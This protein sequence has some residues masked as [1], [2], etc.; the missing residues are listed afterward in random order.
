MNFSEFNKHARLL[1][2]AC[3]CV[4]L[5]AVINSGKILLFLHPR[6]LLLIK[7]GWIVLVALTLNELKTFLGQNSRIKLDWR[8]FALMFPILA[9][10]YVNPTGLS[11]RIAVQKGVSSM[12]LTANRNTPLP[13]CLVRDTAGPVAYTI[14]DDSMYAQLDRLYADP[15][16]HVGEIITMLGFV[17]PDTILG[18]KSFF[19]ARMMV[20]CCAADGMPIGFYCATDS[21][22]GIHENDWVILTGK[23][24][25]RSV[26]FPWNT[27]KKTIPLL[28]MISVKKA[29]KPQNEYVYPVAY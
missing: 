27:D 18:R 12:A 29:T 26:K 9:V 14:K 6:S 24:E 5:Y 4:A 8:Y 22:I 1:T 21:T 7:I 17:A 10:L 19:L 20:A 23:L 3:V 2:L 28:K 11:S 25:T 13:Q 15:V 16:K